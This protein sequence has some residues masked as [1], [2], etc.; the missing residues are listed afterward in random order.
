MRRYEN[1]PLNLNLKDFE[2]YWETV[3]F[4]ELVSKKKRSGGWTLEGDV[5][6]KADDI[7]WNTGYTERVFS[8]EL[9][10]VRNSGTLLRDW[11]EALPWLY[12]EYNWDR[13]TGF[14]SREIVIEPKGRKR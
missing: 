13:I 5:F 8:E 3:F 6:K 9:V 10:P 14:L 1:A 12:M 11:E 7:D 2:K 4:P